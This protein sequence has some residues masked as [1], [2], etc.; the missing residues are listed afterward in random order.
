MTIESEAD[1]FRWLQLKQMIT[2]FHAG[3]I[4]EEARYPITDLPVWREQFR[5]CH[6]R[7]ECSARELVPFLEKQSEEVT[8]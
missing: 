1:A 3:T 2:D 4:K 5:R 7:S 8:R 6:G